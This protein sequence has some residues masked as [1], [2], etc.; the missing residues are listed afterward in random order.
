[1]RNGTCHEQRNRYQKSAREIRM[2]P[3]QSIHKRY[4]LEYPHADPTQMRDP[5]RVRE[6]LD[7]SVK[8]G[9]LLTRVRGRQRVRSCWTAGTQT[10]DQKGV[11]VHET[12]CFCFCFSDKSKSIMGGGRYWYRMCISLINDASIRKQRKRRKRK[13]SSVELFSLRK[14]RKLKKEVLPIIPVPTGSKAT[15]APR[16]KDSTQYWRNEYMY[17]PEADSRKDDIRSRFR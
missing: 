4:L 8:V 3:T 5:H 7:I 6:S 14:R 2:Y 13:L 11:C 17:R 15:I 16:E 9:W 12:I 10:R 1:M